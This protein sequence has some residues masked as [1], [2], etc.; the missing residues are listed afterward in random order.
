MAIEF[1]CIIILFL[2]RDTNLTTPGTL[3]I[4]R[5]LS[6]TGEQITM[7]SVNPHA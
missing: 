6:I 1:S 4:E 7:V 3:D 2:S 5:E